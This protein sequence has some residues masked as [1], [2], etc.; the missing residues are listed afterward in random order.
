MQTTLLFYSIE[1]V[2]EMQDNSELFGKDVTM[3]KRVAVINDLSGLGKCS[4]T[5]AIPVLSVLGVQ[6]CPLP[7]AVLT[8]QTGYDSYYCD[9]YTDKIDY[10]TDEWQKRKLTLDGIYTGF[11]GSEAQ[12]AKILRFN[13]VFRKENTL[14]L[15]DPVMGDLGKAYSIYTPELGRQMRSLALHADVITPNLTECCLLA[16][17]DYDELLSHSGSDDYLKYI[18]EMGRRLL[19]AGIKTVIITG[20]IY[21]SKED[22]SPRYYNLVLTGQECHTISSEIHGGSYSGTGDLLA[23]VVCASIVRGDSAETG[24]RRAVRFLETSLKET[25]VENIPRNDGIN[26]EPYLSLLLH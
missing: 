10:Y 4:L 20:I 5:A 25:A 8:N 23:S 12:V 7:T 21:Q 9:D 11:L 6:A 19:N 17:T 18:T 16:D 15:V 24:V 3:V 22:V 14:L 2:L 1:N 13:E 26:F